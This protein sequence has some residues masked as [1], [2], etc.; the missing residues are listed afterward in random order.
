MSSSLINIGTTLKSLRERS[1]FTQSNIAKY[2]KVDQSLISKYET[3][4]RALTSDMLEKL[5][6]LFGVTPAA[7]NDPAG[8][9]N[10][11][12]LALRASEVNEEDLDAIAA[13]NRIALNCNFMTHLLEDDRSNG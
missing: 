9:S 10:S 3:G 12:T 5:A 11:L 6:A 4:E 8:Q 7:F 13:I 2:L 1:G